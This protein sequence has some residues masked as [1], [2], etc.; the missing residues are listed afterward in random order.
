MHWAFSLISQ[1]VAHFLDTGTGRECSAG[2]I[3]TC[4]KGTTK[5]TDKWL[6]K[7][8]YMLLNFSN[9]QS[10][11]HFCLVFNV[12]RCYLWN[13]T[14]YYKTKKAS[15]FPSVLYRGTANQ[16]AT[17]RGCIG[18]NKSIT[19][20]LQHPKGM[21]TVLGSSAIAYQAWKEANKVLIC[22]NLTFPSAPLIFAL[23]QKVVVGERIALTILF[24]F[25]N[26]Y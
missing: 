13:Y 24:Q 19:K 17:N 11:L 25:L 1:E 2:V 20:V 4:W 23:E 14:F 5:Y 8:I 3:N 15:H 22:M 16:G 10:N 6:S 21:D 26:I 12:W 7:D 18:G 9:R